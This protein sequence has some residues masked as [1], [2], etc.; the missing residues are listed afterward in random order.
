MT[1]GAALLD[2]LDDLTASAIDSGT[3]LIWL[4][5]QPTAPSRPEALRSGATVDTAKFFHNLTGSG[6]AL[7]VEP[8]EAQA[9]V[10]QSLGRFRTR[11]ASGG[12]FREPLAK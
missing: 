12:P 7:P 10:V 3:D 2:V 8:A 9:A 4:N 1:K 5:V 6:G 11:S